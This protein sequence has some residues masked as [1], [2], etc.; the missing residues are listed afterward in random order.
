MKHMKSMKLFFLFLFFLFV[1]PAKAGIHSFSF[2]FSVFLLLT[3][4]S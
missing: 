2:L 1:I 3:T 4:E